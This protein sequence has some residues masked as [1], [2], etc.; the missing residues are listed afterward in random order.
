MGLWKTLFKPKYPLRP[1]CSDSSC[2]SGQHSFF[3]HTE[4]DPFWNE[5]I[6][7][8]YQIRQVREFLHDQLQD[9]KQGNIV[10]LGFIICCK[11]MGF[12][13]PTWQRH[14]QVSMARFS[15]DEEEKQT[16]GQGT[17]REKLCF[18]GCF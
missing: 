6:M 8:Y 2:L 10:F 4:Q 3:P 1:A 7:I 15:V 13:F 11:G 16:R 12:T 17:V 9:R 14:I 18:W 5:D